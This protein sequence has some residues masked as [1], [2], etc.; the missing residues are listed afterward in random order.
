VLYTCLFATQGTDLRAPL[1]QG[2]SDEQLGQL[3]AN[4]WQNREDRYSEQRAA[5]GSNEHVLRKIEMYY[6]GG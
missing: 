4:A 6:I 3:I 2:A 5:L 1:R